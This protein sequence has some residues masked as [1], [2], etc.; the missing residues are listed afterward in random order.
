MRLLKYSCNFS[1]SPFG[2]INKYIYSHKWWRS[3]SVRCFTNSYRLIYH[4]KDI[5][6]P[7]MTWA[8]CKWQILLQTRYQSCTSET[9]ITIDRSKESSVQLQKKHE[10][11]GVTP[12]AESLWEQFWKRKQWNEAMLDLNLTTLSWFITIRALT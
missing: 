7:L 5:Q 2:N 10:I 4:L 6:M 1:F 3:F 8:I 9:N 12:A 11:T